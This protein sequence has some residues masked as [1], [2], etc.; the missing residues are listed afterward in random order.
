VFKARRKAIEI[1]RSW[2]DTRQ[3]PK[4]RKLF[5][6]YFPFEYLG[7]FSIGKRCDNLNAENPSKTLSTHAIERSARRKM[8]G[9]IT[10]LL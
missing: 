2:Q 4:G 9:L 3:D 5:C 7:Q 6:S 10:F 1:K 8:N